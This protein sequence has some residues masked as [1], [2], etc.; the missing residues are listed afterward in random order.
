MF[1]DTVKFSLTEDEF[2]TLWQEIITQFKIE[3]NKYF[4]KMW[5]NRERFIPVYYKNDFFPFIQ[6]TG[7]SE[8]TNTRFKDNVGPTY[9]LVNFLREYQKNN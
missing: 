4:S 5:T 3:N 9:S 6:S 2:E 1:E 8:G 7:R